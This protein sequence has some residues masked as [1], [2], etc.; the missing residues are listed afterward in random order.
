MLHFRL[1]DGNAVPV[2]CG[3]ANSTMTPPGDFSSDAKFFV[4]TGV[5]SFLS[6]IAILVV[7][8]FFSGVYSSES[9]RGPQIVSQGE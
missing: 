9:K 3:K 8:V 5:I 7:Y 1:G 2:Q 4:F 6:T